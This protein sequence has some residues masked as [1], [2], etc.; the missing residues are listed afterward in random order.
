MRE[1]KRT[2]KTAKIIS[3]SSSMIYIHTL[4]STDVIRKRKKMSLV[5]ITYLFDAFDKM[6]VEQKRRQERMKLKN[7]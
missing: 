2:E 1:R 4:S 5:T 7:I 6:N 3:F